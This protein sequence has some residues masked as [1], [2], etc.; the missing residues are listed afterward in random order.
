MKLKILLIIVSL[1]MIFSSC[2]LTLPADVDLTD[3]AGIWEGE[4]N[5]I[6]LNLMVDS[7]GKV[8]GSGV[9][10]LWSTDSKGNVT[11]G[12]GF[13]F[14]SG[15]HYIIANASWSLQL[16]S[17]KTKLSGE[18][19]VAYSG[20]HNM[21][22]NL[23]KSDSSFIMVYITSLYG[24]TVS[25]TVDIA[26]TARSSNAIVKVEFY[27]DESLKS[28]DISSPYSYS[29]NTTGYNNGSYTIEVIAYDTDGQTASDQHMAI[30]SNH[31]W[32][33]LTA[34]YVESSPAIGSDGTIYVGSW[35]NKLYAINPDG[36]KKWEFLTGGYVNPS[37][38][39]GS[40]GTIY[41]GSNDDKLYAINPDGTKKWEFLI[42]RDVNSSP[43]IGSDGTIYI[44]SYDNKL[45]AINSDGT[46][47]W[48]FSTDGN[49]NSS[50]AIGSDGTIYVGSDDKK[51][52]AIY[53]S[54]SL[55]N[56]PWPM[57]HHDLKHTGR[58]E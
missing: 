56:T 49:V 38:T 36:T 58:K 37:P 40:D 51:L 57:F 9:S 16:N 20:L 27:I 52:Y 31:K 24:S 50:P 44:G 18:F 47:K 43:A 8:S 35:D 19:D 12:G 11:G 15:G 21:N 23:T 29:W 2:S 53:G 6:S 22:V 54:G 48:E 41:I 10:S 30:V 42:G 28:T 4:A 5:S 45:Y 1:I 7:E 25:D 3:L 55:A 46:K 34:G 39:I 13:G 26:V 14:T 32:E 33:F 17:N